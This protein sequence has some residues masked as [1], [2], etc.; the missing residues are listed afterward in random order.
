MRKLTRLAAICVF[1][2]ALFAADNPFVG[3]WKLNTA[4]SKFSP[5]TAL[6]EMTVTFEAVGSEF[7]RT[8]T[9]VDAD[10]QPISQGS[11]VAWDGMDHKID[12]PGGTVAVKVVNDHTSNFTIKHE[13][14]IVDSGRAVVS[15][16]GKAM[17]VT[18]KG[19][20]QKG[21]KVD[22]TEVFDK[23]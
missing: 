6:K 5:G 18:E 13:G 20:D 16:D 3:T 7:K 10:G 21:R 15:K 8:A 17:T 2:A 9:G 4:K 22:S 19:E 12:M 14:K 1:S 11:T 23:Q